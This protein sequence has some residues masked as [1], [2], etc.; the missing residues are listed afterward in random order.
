MHTY[1]RQAGGKGRRFNSCRR[2]W[3]NRSLD[4]GRWKKE[5]AMSN[6]TTLDRRQAQGAFEDACNI[7]VD[8]ILAWINDNLQPDQVFEEGNLQAWAE[9]NG[10]VQEE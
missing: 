2:S 4:R 8:D 3:Y 10:Y 5:E 1:H 6:L 9:A 7:D